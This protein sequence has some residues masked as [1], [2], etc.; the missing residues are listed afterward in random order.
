MAFILTSL[1]RALPA[2]IGVGEQDGWF[3][4][5]A[6]APAKRVHLVASHR[7]PGRN[8]PRGG[9]SYWRDGIVGITDTIRSRVLQRERAP[10]IY[11]G[12]SGAV[13]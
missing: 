1:R 12:W 10:G 11:Q 4:W 13:Y 5:V 7:T 9:G 2:P 3:V 8:H 6:L